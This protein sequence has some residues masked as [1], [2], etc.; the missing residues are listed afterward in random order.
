MTLLSRILGML[1]SR[2]L[3]HY[4]GA[5]LAADAFFVA[6]R[7][8]NLLRRF[9]AEGVMVAA[10]IT[11]IHEVEVLEGEETGRRFIARFVGSLTSLLTLITL[12]G[13]VAMPLII[14]LMELG[15][16]DA[17]GVGKLAQLGRILLGY[18]PAPPEW[19]LTTLLGRIMFAYILLVSLSAALGGV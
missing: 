6:F 2:V 9:T 12:A 17:H 5:S 4:L 7:L 16:V 19:A 10:F 1:E 3:A 11:T 13:I 15:K 8:P 14:G 18:A